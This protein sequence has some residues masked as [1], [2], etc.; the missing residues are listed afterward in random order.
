MKFCKYFIYRQQTESHKRFEAVLEPD[1]VSGALFPS[2]FT[3]LTW[4]TTTPNPP[5][6]LISQASKVV[7]PALAAVLPID[8]GGHSTALMPI[9]GAFCSCQRSS[10]GPEATDA[11]TRIVD[12][13]QASHQ[14]SV[15]I[16]T[17]Q[18]GHLRRPTRRTTH[19]APLIDFDEKHLIE[20]ERPT[21]SSQS[22]I[23]SVPSTHVTILTS[24]RNGASAS[25]RQ[26]YD[27]NALGPPP[28]YHSRR[29]ASPCP[30]DE[31]IPEHPVMAR[32]WLERLQN[33]ARADNDPFR[34]GSALPRGVY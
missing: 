27:S 6:C 31:T 21:S 4:K 13:K 12:V 33:Q 19:S 18:A 29:S 34:D 3:P 15:S 23:V 32:D 24:S 30:S 14:T 2:G 25:N 1:P 9:M 7:A 28:S 26:S 10:A 8:C 16:P 11:Y 20:D 22:S 5:S 17:Y